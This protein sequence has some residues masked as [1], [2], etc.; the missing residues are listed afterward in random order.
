MQ[1]RNPQHEQPIPDQEEYCLASSHSELLVVHSCC[2]NTRGHQQHQQQYSI[3]VSMSDHA[4][5]VMYAHLDVTTY[6]NFHKLK[7]KCFEVILGRVRTRAA[8]YDAD[9]VTMADL[10]KSFTLN[11]KAFGRT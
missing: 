3:F 10:T 2:A 7:H 4:I 11:Y 9:Q 8:G 1:G 6:V 5:A